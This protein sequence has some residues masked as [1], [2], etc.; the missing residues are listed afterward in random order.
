MLLP[1][2]YSLARSGWKQLKTRVAKSSSQNQGLAFP[3]RLEC[4]LCSHKK[5]SKLQKI[6]VSV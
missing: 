3:A 4:L 5:L 2:T 6:E 1:K